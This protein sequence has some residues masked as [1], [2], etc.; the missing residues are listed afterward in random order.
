MNRVD[1]TCRRRVT[2]RSGR[3]RGLRLAGLLGLAALPLSCEALAALLQD[4]ALTA[5][6][7]R[8]GWSASPAVTEGDKT[9]G[10]FSLGGAQAGKEAVVATTEDRSDPDYVCTSETVDAAKSFDVNFVTDDPAS[11]VI[12]P[13]SLLYGETLLT[14]EYVPILGDRAPVTVSTNMAFIEGEPKVVV[15]DPSL[16]G[17][18]TAVNR[19]M[20][21]QNHGT[22]GAKLSFESKEVFSSEQLNIAVNGKVST[23]MVDVAGGFSLDRG[24]E[25]RLIVSKFLQEYYR[26][27]VDP[28]DGPQA[29]FQGGVLPAFEPN[30]TPVYVSSVSYGRA[31][32]FMLETDDRSQ[33]IEA[34]LQVAYNGVTE[35]EVE[36]E[37]TFEKLMKNGTMKVLVIGG[38]APVVVKSI[39]GF[40][41]FKQAILEG[42]DFH[43]G[44]L[45]R[46][47]AYT[48]TFLKDNSIANVNLTTQYT[49]RSCRKVRSQYRVT[50][51]Y[52]SSPYVSNDEQ[53]DDGSNDCNEVWGSATVEGNTYTIGDDDDAMVY[54]EENL[55]NASESKR[56][57]IDKSYVVN[58]P[59]SEAKTFEFDISLSLTDHDTWSANDSFSGSTAIG[60]A[61]IPIGE[62]FLEV[63]NGTDKIRLYYTINAVDD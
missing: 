30:R 34:D 19:M 39:S 49:K 35:V 1:S 26:L 4:P 52:L 37:T 55:E 46:P 14:G 16:S 40:E 48:L 8:P 47:I 42:A 60:I 61:D 24:R 53:A 6:D 12:Y 7:G 50:L 9:E 11:S 20:V 15:D 59:E 51:K 17:V 45:G 10:S 56:Y 32:Y 25:K 41:G 36:A 5:V 13:G 31:A 57:R 27:D 3:S 22:L 54:L 23:A 29:F 21:Q 38:D 33:N 58:V 2:E 44:S 18:R 63:N 62:D 28:P 43:A